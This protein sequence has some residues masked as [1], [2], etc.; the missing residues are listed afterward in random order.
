MVRD[1]EESLEVILVRGN[2]SGGYL[3]LGG[4]PLGQSGEAAIS[5]ETLLEEVAGATIR[6]PANKEITAAARQDLMPLPGWDADP[7]LKRARA[8]ILDATLSVHLG[9]YHLVYDHSLGLTHERKT[10][11]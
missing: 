8:L 9:G 6:L 5:D 7:W 11:R 2:P 3:T 10:P 4:R 1:G